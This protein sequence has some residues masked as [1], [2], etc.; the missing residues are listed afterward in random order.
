MWCLARP[1]KISNSCMKCCPIEPSL[2]ETIKA[3]DFLFSFLNKK[4]KFL[5][6]GREEYK[7]DKVS[8]TNE[9]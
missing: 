4:R 9:A 8:K 7:M 1:W 2:V 6:R 5:F 3:K